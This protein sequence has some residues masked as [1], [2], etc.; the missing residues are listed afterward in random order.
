[1]PTNRLL[2]IFAFD[3]LLSVGASSLHCDGSRSSWIIPADYSSLSHLHHIPQP[4]NEEESDRLEWK[5]GVQYSKLEC[6]NCGAVVGRV[7]RTQ[8]SDP[9]RAYA[10]KVMLHRSALR[11][12]YTVGSGQAYDEK[13]MGT[14]QNGGEENTDETVPSVLESVMTML[15]AQREELQAQREELHRLQQTMFEYAQHF[16]QQIGGA[17]VQAQSPQQTLP[18]P[19]TAAAAATAAPSSSRT[20]T[21]SKASPPVNRSSLS[22]LS[23]HS[24]SSIPLTHRSVPSSHH[25][26]VKR[27]SSTTA[28]SISAQLSLPSSSSKKSA[29]ASSHH[30]SPREPSSASRQSLQSFMP[31]I[32]YSTTPIPDP[33]INSRTVPKKPTVSRKSSERVEMR[34]FEGEEEDLEFSNGDDDDDEDQDVDGDQFEFEP[35]TVKRRAASNKRSK[36]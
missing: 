15:L 7:W 21:A 28:G 16:N 18:P 1:M 19:S 12:P 34:Y 14:T 13:A 29:N 3:V 27:K 8:P 23:S 10:G 31:P 6:G 30:R 24:T 20:L 4:L 17:T 5:Y 25:A 2:F 9:T 32:A 11:Q 36:A 26:G 33:A 22:S 35:T